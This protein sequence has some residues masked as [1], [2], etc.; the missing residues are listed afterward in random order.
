MS[1]AQPTFDDVWR[2]FQET[3]LLIKELFVSQNDT[4]RKFQD[5]ERLLNEKFQETAEVIKEVNKQIGDLGNRLGD[6]VE[7][8]VRPAAVRL[9]QER[10]IEVHE[11]HQNVTAQRD[12]DGIQVDLLVINNDDAIA[13]ECKSSLSVDDVDE[14]TE[15]LGKL[16]K[17]LPKYADLRV[18]G[19][20]AAMVLPDDVA[21]YAYRLKTKGHP[22]CYNHFFS[23]VG[24]VAVLLATQ[25]YEERNTCHDLSVMSIRIL[26]PPA[27]RSP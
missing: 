19:A 4:D 16:K 9:F 24:W 11:V 22:L 6:F 3:N 7:W 23:C 13:I 25:L 14:H 20:V 17:L 12:D 2:M 27:T 8:T 26:M 1:T 15:R 18:L 5:T 10:G 21:K